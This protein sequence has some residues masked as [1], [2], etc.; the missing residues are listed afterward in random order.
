[1]LDDPRIL[2]IET[3]AT[4]MVIISNDMLSYRVEHARGDMH[5][6]IGILTQRDGL[7]VQDAMNWA[8][9]RGRELMAAA[10]KARAELPSFGERLDRDVRNYVTGLCDWVRACDD[11]SFEGQRYFGEHGREVQKHR[12]IILPKRP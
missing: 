1:M 8:N 10:Q 7:S 2:E 11:F 6:V 3:L 4:D 12:R 5:S 9:R